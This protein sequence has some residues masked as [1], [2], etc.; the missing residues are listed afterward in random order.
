LAT[1]ASAF[2]TSSKMDQPL[3]THPQNVNSLSFV[4]LMA[5]G[6]GN[7]EV[8][9]TADF[10]MS[11]KTYE[12]SGARVL[13]VDDHF[14]DRHLDR[15]L[16]S[17]SPIELFSLFNDR[18]LKRPGTNIGT[19]G[20]LT[21]SIMLGL[22][23]IHDTLK[24]Q[25]VLKVDTDSLIIRPF[26][27]RVYQAFREQPEAGVIGEYI[28]ELADVPTMFK[29]SCDRLTRPLS[30]WR[31]RR[32]AGRRFGQSIVGRGATIRHHIAAAKRAGWRSPQHC[33]GGGYALSW[34]ALSSL[35]QN[36]YLDDH[37]LWLRTPVTEDVVVSLYTRAAGFQLYCHNGPGTPFGIKYQGLLGDPQW[38]VDSG[39]SIIHSLKTHGPYNEERTRNFFQLRRNAATEAR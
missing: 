9:R 35:R 26:A 16:A 8:D 39:V 20:G 37:L 25:F 18:P 38:L 23:R 2:A 4:V 24:G 13:L 19:T 22:R 6:P 7:H 28:P 31:G 21:T 5:V 3:V 1:P 15:L 10:L 14:V 32:K 30:F 33:Q 11:L 27:D 29:D 36:G 12:P 34:R 17:V